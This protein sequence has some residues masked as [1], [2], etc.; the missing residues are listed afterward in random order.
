[1][2]DSS[3]RSSSVSPEI[4]THYESSNEA[5]RLLNSFGQ[6]E[7]ARTQAIIQ[8]Y[9]PPPPAVIMDVGGGAGIHSCWLAKMGYEVHL[10]DAVPLHVEQARQASQAQADHP[11]ASIEVGD[12]RKL[13][14][15]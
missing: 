4:V 1:M 2:T 10:V 8:R 13:D 11:L 3:E 14:R 5:E 15:A 12:A 9:L 6:L 7:L